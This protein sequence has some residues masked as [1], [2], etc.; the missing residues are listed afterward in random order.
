MLILATIY[1]FISHYAIVE[2]LVYYKKKI[3]TK[4]SRRKKVLGL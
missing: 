4:I 3:S 2:R 1:A